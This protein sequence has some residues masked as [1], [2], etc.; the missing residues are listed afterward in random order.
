V[1]R[2]TFRQRFPVLLSNHDCRFRVPGNRPLCTNGRDD[3]SEQTIPVTEDQLYDTTWGNRVFV[4]AADTRI[5][6]SSD[7]VNQFAASGT[8][9]R[10]SSG[11]W[12][13]GYFTLVGRSGVILRGEDGITRADESLEITDPHSAA[14]N[15]MVDVAVGEHGAILI[16]HRAMCADVFESGDASEWSESMP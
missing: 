10:L 11:N 1:I 2:Y 6:Y 12:S 14:S 7:G 16:R 15:S 8:Y 5:L 4:I 9:P 13:G 3:W